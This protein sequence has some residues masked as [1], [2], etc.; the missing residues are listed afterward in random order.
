MRERAGLRGTAEKNILTSQCFSH[1]RNRMSESSDPLSS[2]SGGSPLLT[3]RRMN[4]KAISPPT[5]ISMVN[6]KAA[7]PRM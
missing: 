3:D 2:A 7:R 1:R 4:L 5:F 6:M